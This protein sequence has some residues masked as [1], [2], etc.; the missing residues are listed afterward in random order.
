MTA[1]TYPIDEDSFAVSTVTPT[2]VGVVGLHNVRT[3]Q[4]TP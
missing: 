3:S 1:T 4:N 2:F